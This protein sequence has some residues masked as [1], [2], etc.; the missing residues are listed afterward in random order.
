MKKNFTL[1]ELLVVIA[2]IAILAAMLLPALNKAREK[3]LAIK[4]AGNLKNIGLGIAQYT[5]DYHDYLPPADYWCYDIGPYVSM[6]DA[7]AW[8]PNKWPYDSRKNIFWCVRTTLGVLPLASSLRGASYDVTT[9]NYDTGGN[10]T[11]LGQA[12]AHGYMAE[13]YN[14]ATPASAV[15]LDKTKKIT[16]IYPASVIAAEV[17]A[18]GTRIPRLRFHTAAYSELPYCND[19][20]QSSWG[21]DYCHAGNSNA[22]SA[23]GRV[24]TI[25]KGSLF[26]LK[27]FVKK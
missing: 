9:C 26:D 25:K 12:N 16:S 14:P 7:A 19:P 13:Y 18:G 17:Q 1:I 23:D 4:C 20:T 27:T 11:T 24:Q 6:G 5:G 22:L 2:I 10:P 8:A 15:A 21:I 3:G